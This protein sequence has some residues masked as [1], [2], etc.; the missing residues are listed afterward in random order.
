MTRR[1]AA[2]LILAAPVVGCALHVGGERMPVPTP[3]T[4]SVPKGTGTL[5][6]VV[7][8]PEVVALKPRIRE[9]LA[10]APVTPCFEAA[11]REDPAVYGEVIV[12]VRLRADGSVAHAEVFH[13]TVPPGMAACVAGRMGSVV[14]PAPPRDGFAVR[15]PYLFT[16][17]TT[18][19]EAARALRVRHGLE[20]AIPE[21]DPHD[22]KAPRPEG[23]V[24]LW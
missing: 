9:A 7:L 18:P 22:P 23:V 2:W 1:G 12:D 24:T 19:S 8:P 11:L 3:A 20:P 4:A 16:A 17:N 15:Y 21:G 6:Q 14:F 5:V 13:A 10:T